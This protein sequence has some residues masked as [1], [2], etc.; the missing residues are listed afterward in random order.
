MDTTTGGAATITLTTGS[1]EINAPLLLDKDLAI[2]S[3]SA[4]L[5]LSGNITGTGKTISTT[6]NVTLSGVN[7]YG[8]TS[9]DNGTVTFA[10]ALALPAGS[11]VTTTGTRRGG[12]QQRL[13]GRD[14]AAARVPLRWAARP[15]CPSRARSSCWLAAALCGA[16]A[17][18]RRKV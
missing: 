12:L 6:G 13:H 18:L 9:V 7:N 15:R 5:T 11:N 16:A 10:N 1:H 2:A 3:N 4:G 14:H 8:G 17:W